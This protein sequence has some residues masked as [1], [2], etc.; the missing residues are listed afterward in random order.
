M[1]LAGGSMRLNGEP[2]GTVND[3]IKH[4]VRSRGKPPATQRR[5][6]WHCKNSFE[7]KNQS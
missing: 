2:I 6:K 5:K 7:R 1:M 4:Y 3:G